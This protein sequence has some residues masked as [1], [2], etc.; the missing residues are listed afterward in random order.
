MSLSCHK[1]SGTA[2]SG[3]LSISSLCDLPLFA[4]FSCFS[5]LFPYKECSVLCFCEPWLT[6]SIPDAN[7]QLH[8]CSSVTA[9][10]DANACR[11]HKGGGLA[12]YV[13][14]RLTLRSPMCCSNRTPGGEP[15]S[16]LLAQGVWT[17]PYR[18]CL[19][20]ATSQHRS[21]G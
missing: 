2:V 19:H 17:R 6:T 20:P 8:G 11:K 10:R 15:A 13:S 4:F 21:R 16:L 3:S 5:R 14:R 12:I 9:E 18:C 1:I 7:L